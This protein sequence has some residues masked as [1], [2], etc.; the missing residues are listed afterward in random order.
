MASQTY[1][2]DMGTRS[3]SRLITG[4][5]AQNG[6]VANTSPQTNQYLGLTVKKVYEECRKY[7]WK[8]ELIGVN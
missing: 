5:M 4:F 3:G 8:L 6:K 7:G 2:I 1:Q